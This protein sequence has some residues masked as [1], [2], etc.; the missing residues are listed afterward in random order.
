MGEPLRTVPD[1]FKRDIYD[2]LKSCVTV[3]KNIEG[4]ADIHKGTNV[5]ESPVLT[6]DFLIVDL[7]EFWGIGG[8]VPTMEIFEIPCGR[9]WVAMRVFLES[10]DENKQGWFGI[11]LL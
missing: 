5:Y 6:T 3:E 8:F 10:F 9:H 7:S 11:D 2:A 4:D 1:D